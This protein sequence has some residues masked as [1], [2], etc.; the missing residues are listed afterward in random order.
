MKGFSIILHNAPEVEVDNVGHVRGSS[1]AEVR[2]SGEDNIVQ[3]RREKRAMFTDV[4]ES[5][6]A[7][8]GGSCGDK[9]VQKS[10]EKRV[11]VTRKIGGSNNSSVKLVQMRG[12]AGKRGQISSGKPCFRRLSAWFGLNHGDMHTSDENQNFVHEPETQQSQASTSSRVEKADQTTNDSAPVQAVPA[13]HPRPARRATS[14]PIRPREKSQR[15]LQKKLSRNNSGV[16][17]SRFN[18]NSSS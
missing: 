11:K 8:V 15:I 1:V 18:K 5:S 3:T 17:S 16:G 13:D 10:G 6:V 9:V 12:G 2:V 7:E 14:A 4:G